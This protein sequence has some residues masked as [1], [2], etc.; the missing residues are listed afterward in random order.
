MKQKQ[1]SQPSF[2]RQTYI[3]AVGSVDPSPQANDTGLFRQHRY[4]MYTVQALALDLL[5]L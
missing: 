1:F 5:D 3:L 2:S 4:S